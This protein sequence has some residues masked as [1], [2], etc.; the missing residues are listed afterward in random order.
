MAILRAAH[1]NGMT[2]N[3]DKTI[4]NNM[5]M[6]HSRRH[7]ELRDK[8]VVKNRVNEGETRMLLEGQVSKSCG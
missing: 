7:D 1:I 5:T 2:A 3:N 6:V 8:D 4:S